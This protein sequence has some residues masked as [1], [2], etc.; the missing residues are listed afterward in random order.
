MCKSGHLESKSRWIQMHHYCFESESGGYWTSNPSPAQKALIPDSH[1]SDSNFNRSKILKSLICTCAQ[2]L[3]KA[4]FYSRISIL[5]SDSACGRLWPETYCNP[6]IS[7][8]FEN[9]LL[10]HGN[11]R[12]LVEEVWYPN[13]PISKNRY[14]PTESPSRRI[15]IP[16]SQFQQTQYPNIPISLFYRLIIPISQFQWLI[17]THF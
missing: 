14:P 7:I 12:A 10:K 6:F 15:D 11:D 3:L 13:N 9:H 1:V 2:A 8:G 4:L 17:S 5:F 16:G